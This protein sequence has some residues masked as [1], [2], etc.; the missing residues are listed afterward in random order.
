[1]CSRY[2]LKKADAIKA[3]AEELAGEGI[4]PAAQV[5]RYNVALSDA[6]PVILR[7]EGRHRLKMLSFGFLS[8]SREPGK[9]PGLLANGRIETLQEKTLFR[10]SVAIRRCL[11]PA[12]GFYEW[13]RQGTAR[14][15]HY[16]YL[17]EPVPFY[18]AGLWQ[19]D[20]SGAPAAFAIVTTRANELVQSVHERMPVILGPNSSRA[21]LGE[22]PLSAPRLAQF[23]RPLPAT[24]MTGH[25]V[26]ARMN[27]VRY[28]AADCPAPLS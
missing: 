8:S 15:P 27:N 13:E 11:V 4:D 16:F 23:S 24:R 17:R 20:E 12:D 25:R 14:L 26:D 22:T 5:P 18:F 3:F 2:S 1:M 7:Q 21:W 28:Q 6:M 10:T 19:P 9:R